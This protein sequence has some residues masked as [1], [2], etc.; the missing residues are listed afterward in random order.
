MKNEFKFNGMV[1]GGVPML[2]V[3][4]LLLIASVFSFIYMESLGIAL[5]LSVGIVLFLK[6]LLFWFGFVLVEPNKA[7]AMLFFGKY[8]GTIK[9]NGFFFVNP[10]YSKKIL[11]LRANNLNVDPIKVNDKTGNPIMIGLMLVWKIEDTYK[12]LFDIEVEKKIVNIGGPNSGFT[13][14]IKMYNSF[15]KVQSDAALRKLAGSYAY[16]NIEGEHE[17]ITLRSGGEEI[18]ERLEHELSERLAIAGIEVVEARINYLAYASEIAGAMLRRQ[19][20][21]AIIAAREKIVEGAV[22]MVQL[23]LH[24]LSEA[25]VVELDDEKKAAMVSNLMVVLCSDEGIQPVVN[26]GTLYN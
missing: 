10:F 15:V 14:T 19:Q 22:G 2:I 20:A 12:M 3:N 24:K 18:N 5:A 17:E 6:H 23:A 7:C 1:L 25:K 9:T 4:L 11:S 16:D 8:C 13:R 21:S 26:A